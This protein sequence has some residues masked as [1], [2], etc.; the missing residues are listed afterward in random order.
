MLQVQELKDKYGK[1][2]IMVSRFEYPHKDHYTVCRA[3]E[4]L[5]NKY[6]YS[7]PCIQANLYRALKKLSATNVKSL[8]CPEN[9]IARS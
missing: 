3:F 6:P 9:A 7:A 8:K 1:F 5:S 4:I 2:L